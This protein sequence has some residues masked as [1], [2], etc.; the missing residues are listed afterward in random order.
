MNDHELYEVLCTLAA[1]GQ[2][3]APEKPNFEEHCLHCPVCRDQLHDLISIGVRLQFEAAIHPASA[4]MPSGAV[5]RFRAR[6]IREGIA[7]RSTPTKPSPSYTLASAVA[8]FVIVAALVLMPHG[9]KAAESFAI[10]T[11]APILTRQG[12]SASVTGPTLISHPSKATHTKFVRQRLVPHTNVGMND[13]SLAAQRFPRAIT[14]N[15]P[16]FGQQSTT[17]PSVAEFP[18][19]SRSQVSRLDLFRNLDDSNNRKAAGVAAP[20]RSIVIAAT[21][22][23]FDFPA[24]IPQLHFQLPTAQ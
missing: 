9:P 19:L 12:L 6:A 2:L 3:A 14:A 13:A 4:S 11:A 7:P 24:N 16:F 15:Y 1:T 10:S 23:T 17:E 22:N 18:A 5:E 20:D 21:R 8:V